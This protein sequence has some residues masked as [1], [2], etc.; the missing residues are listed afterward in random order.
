VL[1]PLVPTSGN[2]QVRNAGMLADAGAAISI[3]QASTTSPALAEEIIA[4]ITDSPRLENMS[5]A[6]IS[7]ANPDGAANI[8]NEL[9]ELAAR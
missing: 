6:A 8:T 2:E 7:I 1:I 9:L 3:E 4:L 5:L